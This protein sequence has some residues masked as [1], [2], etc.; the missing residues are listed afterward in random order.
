MEHVTVPFTG[1]VR[2]AG[3]ALN[4]FDITYN[5]GDHHLL[6]EVIDLSV[7]HDTNSVTVTASFLLRDNS[8]N[9]DDRF[10]G[11]VDCLIIADVV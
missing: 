9:I 11:H 7:E 2:S 8:G 10:S 1:T 5:N 6:R 4:G 3:A